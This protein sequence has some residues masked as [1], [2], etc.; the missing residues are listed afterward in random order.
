M[1]GDEDEHPVFAVLLEA[2]IIAQ[3]S[4]AL[5][6]RRLP[7]GL[8]MAGFGVL[9]HFGRRPEP[10]TPSS[11][12]RAFQVTKGA[13]TNTLTRLE[14]AGWVAIVPDAADGRVKRVT[15][16]ADGRKVQHAALAAVAPLMSDLTR[17][18]AEADL[19]ALLPTLTRLRT[20]LDE[21]R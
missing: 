4:T 19:I 16:T 3:L 7:P 10:Q 1:S 14:D 15:R 2:N 6:E 5:T 21:H 17:D 13:M 9:N 11:L 18:I 8:S 20:W 12:A